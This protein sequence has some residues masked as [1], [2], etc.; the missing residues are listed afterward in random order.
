MVPPTI[1]T[2]GD[3]PAS[4]RRQREGQW[5]PCRPLHEHACPHT[6]RTALMRR[7]DVVA[8]IH[9]L[10]GLLLGA[11]AVQAE[12]AAPAAADPHALEFCAKPRR[13]VHADNWYQC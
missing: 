10:A 4:R 5:R 8:C 9:S 12:V 1:I 3:F 11:T 6:R 7:T 2:A 13:P